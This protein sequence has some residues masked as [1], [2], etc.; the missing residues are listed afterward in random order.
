[1]NIQLDNREHLKLLRREM[2]EALNAVAAKNGISLHVG[3]ISFSHESAKIKV[4]AKSGNA[5]GKS[6]YALDFE[7][8]Y[9]QFG[10][11]STDLQRTFSINGNTYFLEGL[12]PS[13]SKFPV[14]GRS[15]TGKLFKFS[16]SIV[17]F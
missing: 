10:F 14:V 7:R 17:K 5:V 6:R 2:Q 15:I 12:K 4:E 9:A 11:Q 3:S 16:R 1:M 8:H 13:A